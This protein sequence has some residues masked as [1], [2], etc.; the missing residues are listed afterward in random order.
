MP[1][2]P[3]V[4]A[5]DHLA[6][7]DP[8]ELAGPEDLV[9]LER[10]MARLEAIVAR[11]AERCSEEGTFADDGA[12]TATA[13]LAVRTRRPRRE[14]RAQLELGRLLGQLPAMAEG[15]PDGSAGP[16]GGVA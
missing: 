5:V 3:L 12:M 16:A 8:G 9:A 1:F 11:A 6:A 15:M 2:A 13:W 7:C 14:I 4:E 10:Q